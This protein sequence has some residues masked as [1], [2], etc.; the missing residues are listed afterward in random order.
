M[1]IRG[2]GGRLGIAVVY[3]GFK[4][5][6]GSSVLPLYIMALRGVLC[7]A[8]VYQGFKGGGGGPLSCRCISWL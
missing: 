2:G 8:V 6:E 1:A 4:R 7:L 3:Q 5:G